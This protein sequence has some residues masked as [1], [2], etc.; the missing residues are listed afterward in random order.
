MSGP[1]PAVPA[2]RLRFDAPPP[3]LPAYASALLA[4]RPALGAG[5]PDMPAIEAW[6]SLPPLARRRTE[7]YRQVCGFAPGGALPLTYPHVLAMPLH[8]AMLTAPAFPL[9]VL[10]LVHVRNRIER[11]R[12]V[13]PE[14]ALELRCLLPGLRETER[15]HE[16]DLLT[17]VYQAGALVWSETSGFLARRRESKR[18]G[19]PPGA[20]AGLPARRQTREWRAAANIGR[21]YARVSGD[22]NP[23]HLA[24]W[25]A[26]LF[27][28]PRAIAHGMWSL[29]HAAVLIEADAQASITS[30]DVSFKGPMLL[31]ALVHQHTWAEAGGTRLV[32]TDHQDGKPYLSGGYVLG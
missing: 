13:A 9:R 16:F 22:L 19:A 26:R 1:D 4:R 27:G 10:G 28:F 12:P 31:P 21:R 14:Q 25:S 2:L 23:I 32:L 20:D 11:L 5:A 30:I 3:L 6:V 15:G 17:E 7:A 18:A 8:L 29:A 24:G